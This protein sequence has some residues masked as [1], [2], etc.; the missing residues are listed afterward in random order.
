MA[1][2]L[3][4]VALVAIIVLG[5]DLQGGLAGI[6]RLDW[7]LPMVGAALAM[8]MAMSIASLLTSLI[9]LNA[10]EN[11]FCVPMERASSL[12]AGMCAAW[13]LHGYWNQSAPTADEMYGRGSAACRDRTAWDWR[14]RSE[15]LPAFPPASLYAWF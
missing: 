3:G 7:S 8:G 15:P 9:L 6:L 1:L 4:F 2:P 13:L 12:L 10:R 14:R 5:T 11:S